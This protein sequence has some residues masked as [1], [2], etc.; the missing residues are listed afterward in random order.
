M[1]FGLLI[2]FVQ[3]MCVWKMAD[4][5]LVERRVF[6][7]RY[8]LE[9]KDTPSLGTVRYYIEAVSWAVGGKVGRQ[10]YHVRG[11]R[12]LEGDTVNFTVENPKSNV[13]EHFMDH[14]TAESTF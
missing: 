2:A 7:K 10:S 3:E 6:L 13:F 5:R 4:F 14:H 12:E 9:R 11:S 1:N 8:G